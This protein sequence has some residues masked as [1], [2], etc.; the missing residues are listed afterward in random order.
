MTNTIEGTVYDERRNP[1]F[2]AFVEL[3]NDVNVLTSRARTSTQGRFTF[4]GMSAGNY[5]IKVRPYGTNLLEDSQDVQVNNQ[6]SQSDLVIV[7]FR[8]RIDKRITNLATGTPGETIYVQDIP[9]SAK[10]LYDSGIEKLAKKDNQGLSDLE[11]A[12]KIFPQYFDALSRLGREYVSRKEYEKG[13]PFLLTAIDLNQRCDTCYY[14]LSY[15]FYQLKQY[16]AAAK[17][18]MA[19][20]V[21]DQSSTDIH[22]LLGTVLRLNGDYALSEK[23]LL[24]AKSLAKTP[25]SEIHWQLSLLY[26]KVKRN[27]DAANEL[28]TYLKLVPNASNKRELQEL[29]AKLRTQK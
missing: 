7:E 24:K 26:N 28:E 9:Q 4:R 23:A 16:P 22:L 17:A 5:T 2:N 18:A 6:S 11:S 27:Q 25:N 8:L 15:A 14:S 1:V 10:K 29:I 19:A 12:I 20:A 21:L 13:Y 3:Y